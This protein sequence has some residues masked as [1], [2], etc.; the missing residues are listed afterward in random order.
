MNGTCIWKEKFDRFKYK[1]KFDL[2]ALKTICLTKLCDS[3]FKI[4]WFLNQV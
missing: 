2:Y 4:Q 3:C 1:S